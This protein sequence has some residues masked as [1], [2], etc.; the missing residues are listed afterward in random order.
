MGAPQPNP[1]YARWTAS[2]PVGLA[3]A[4]LAAWLKDNPAPPK[5]VTPPLPLALENFIKDEI[6][7]QLASK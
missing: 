4:D 2:I 6:A 1:G 3:D 5:T 7:R